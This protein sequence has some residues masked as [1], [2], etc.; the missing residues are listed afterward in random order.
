MLKIIACWHSLPQIFAELQ[1]SQGKHSLSG[2]I[3]ALRRQSGLGVE[4]YHASRSLLETLLDSPSPRLLDFLAISQ[5]NAE[6]SNAGL[7]A[8]Q[9]LRKMAVFFDLSLLQNDDMV[10]QRRVFVQMFQ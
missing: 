9:Q 1:S 7:I 2:R 8:V 4:I 6:K 10:L 3:A 5:R